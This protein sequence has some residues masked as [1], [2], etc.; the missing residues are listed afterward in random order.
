MAF[1]VV[2]ELLYC[3]LIFSYN[4]MI[5]VKKYVNP[6]YSEY[7]S[8]NVFH[9][10]LTTILSNPHP[11]K[12]DACRK[13][14]GGNPFYCHIYFTECYFSKYDSYQVKS[15]C[16]RGGKSLHKPMKIKFIMQSI[17]HQVSLIPHIK[18]EI[19]ARTSSCIYRFICDVNDHLCHKY[20]DG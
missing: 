19:N 9:N 3:V 20:S 1:D 7:S 5:C 14:H 11:W 13:F 10:Y 15:L 12:N 6:I 17:R 8:C 16:Q 2:K 18:I 4:F